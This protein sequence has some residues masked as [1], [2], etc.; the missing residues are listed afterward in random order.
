MQTRG[1]TRKSREN[2]VWENAKLWAGI[3]KKA[4]S[5][6]YSA[7]VK[8]LC[9]WIDA[10]RARHSPNRE[11]SWDDTT[12]LPTIFT[13]PRIESVFWSTSNYRPATSFA[14]SRTSEVIPG[15]YR[16]EPRAFNPTSCMYVQQCQLSTGVPRA[17]AWI[18]QRRRVAPFVIYLST[19]GVRLCPHP[20]AQCLYSL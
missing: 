13:T 18:V 8:K 6:Q 9:T 14:L 4:T 20:L 7:S 17:P 11:A 10:S 12:A 2:E 5:T 15:A 1:S 19:S 16:L 3:V